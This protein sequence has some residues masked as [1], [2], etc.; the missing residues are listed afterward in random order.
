MDIFVLFWDP[1]GSFPKYYSPPY[2][3]ISI[4]WLN[5]VVKMSSCCECVYNPEHDGLPINTNWFMQHG[6]TPHTANINAD[7][8]PDSSGPSVASCQYPDLHT[9]G[10]ENS[11]CPE[12]I[13]LGIIFYNLVLVHMYAYLYH[14]LW[15]QY[16]C[17]V[18]TGDHSVCHLVPLIKDS[19]FLLEKHLSHCLVTSNHKWVANKWFLWLNTIWIEG[20]TG[21][22]YY[23]HYFSLP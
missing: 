2:V 4:A 12:Y 7:F 3:T 1:A 15:L 6:A 19:S 23:L 13:L 5:Y 20:T 14:I 18:W 22:F 17:K 11:N 9:Y 16:L 21:L 8:S 10:N